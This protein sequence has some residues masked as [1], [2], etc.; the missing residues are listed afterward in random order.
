MQATIREKLASC[1][2]DV[3]VLALGGGA[4]FGLWLGPSLASGSSGS[5]ST[6]GNEPLAEHDPERVA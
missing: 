2:I 6:F 3:P 5:S 4:H 1:D